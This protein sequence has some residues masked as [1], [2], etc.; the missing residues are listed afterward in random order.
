M[1]VAMTMTFGSANQGLLA[2][3]AGLFPLQSRTED[4]S[5]FLLMTAVLEHLSTVLWGRM[6]T[7]V[8]L[9]PGQAKGK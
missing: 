7:G 8:R 5:L 9:L 1:V 3:I 6:T 4:L 2:T